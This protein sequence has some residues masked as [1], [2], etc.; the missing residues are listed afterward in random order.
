[1]QVRVLLFL[2]LALSV[3]GAS[4]AEGEPDTTAPE[5]LFLG[6]QSNNANIRFAK[7]GDSI[8]INLRANEPI[9]EPSVML[10]GRVVD[11]TTYDD[12]AF[13]FGSIDVVSED[14]EGPVSFSI[15]YEDIAG[16]IV[17]D[18]SATTD[19]VTV[20]VD[21]TA[22]T[23]VG[24]VEDVAL[25]AESPAGFVPTYHRQAHHPAGRAKEKEG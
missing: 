13:Y 25:E 14:V 22:P 7:V 16:N 3:P 15:T 21:G 10:L 2:L 19:G 17:T 6:M 5:L 18:V 9:R 24:T 8:T 1:M 23:M 12:P 4:F 20:T 11:M